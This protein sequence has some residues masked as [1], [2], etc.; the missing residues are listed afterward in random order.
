[1]NISIDIGQDYPIVYLNGYNENAIEN[2][3]TSYNFTQKVIADGSSLNYNT[4][5]Y[6]YNSNI[7]NTLNLDKGLYTLAGTDYNYN[8]TNT[9]KSEDYAGNTFITKIFVDMVQALTLILI[10]ETI[11]HLQDL[12]VAII[13]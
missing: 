2:D 1:M 12:Q 8:G 10:L 6:K 3:N 4:S 11:T 7:L 13:Q 9:L 5:Y